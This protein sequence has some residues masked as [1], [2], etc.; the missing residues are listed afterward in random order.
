MCFFVRFNIAS[1]AE[2]QPFIEILFANMYTFQHTERQKH[3]VMFAKN[4]N[5]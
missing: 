4:G 2:Q 1:F 5:N 3:D